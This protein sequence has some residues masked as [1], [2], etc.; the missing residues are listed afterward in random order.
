MTKRRE[1][2]LGILLVLTFLAFFF[3]STLSPQA[4]PVGW[5]AI[6]EDNFKDPNFREFLKEHY[7]KNHDKFL[8]PEE[9][10]VTA[11]DCRQ[12]NISDLQGIE[13]FTKL[14]WLNCCD[15]QL[16]S[17]D[18]SWN[19]ELTY[20]DCDRNFLVSLNLTQNAKLETLLCFENQLS[21]LDLSGNPELI[22]LNCESNQLSDLNLSQNPKLKEL[23][24]A[25]NNLTSLE[26]SQNVELGQFSCYRNHLTSLDL[27]SQSKL[28]NWE[29]G[30]QRADLQATFDSINELYLFDLTSFPGV[31]AGR[32]LEIVGPLNDSLSD[33][34]GSQLF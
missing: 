33:Y 8:S 30:E 22:W 5:L 24:C 32:I 1:R 11:M 15:N 13:Y 4:T 2:T 14:E 34:D 20:L 23:H 25:V 10:A 12:C 26:L 6:R 17:L 18:L 16:T 7:D 28:W 21:N 27:N 31:E 3:L 19:P 29:A 9:L